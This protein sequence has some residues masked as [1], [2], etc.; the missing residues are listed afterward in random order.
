M[1][2]A[3]GTARETRRFFYICLFL[4]VT[5]SMPI[6]AQTTATIVGTLADKTG[7]VVPGASITAM[8]TDTGLRREVKTNASGTY[9]IPALA[10]GEYSVTAAARSEEHTSE[11][12]SLRHL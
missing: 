4:I 9:V 11:L 12:Q 6:A 7:A 10:V 5:L 1:T 8:G 3:F 2:T